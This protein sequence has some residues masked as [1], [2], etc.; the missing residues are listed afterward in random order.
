MTSAYK[1]VSQCGDQSLSRWQRHKTGSHNADE[2]T[3]VFLGVYSLRY[4]RPSH[5]L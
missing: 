3:L 4:P 2:S 5:Y 1:Q